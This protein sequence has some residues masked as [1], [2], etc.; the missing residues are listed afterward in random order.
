[1]DTFT[2]MLKYRQW[3]GNATNSAVSALAIVSH[4]E[5]TLYA[6]SVIITHGI[7]AAVVI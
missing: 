7:N 5:D 2:A 1:L 4:Y 6:I 3:K